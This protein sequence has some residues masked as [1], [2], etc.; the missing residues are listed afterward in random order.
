MHALLSAQP[1]NQLFSH[2]LSIGI[3]GYTKCALKL[4][5]NKKEQITAKNTIMSPNFLVWEF[6]GKAQFP[7]SFGQM[8]RNYVE[9]MPFH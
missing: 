6:C 2:R 8:T 7:H 1:E 4:W 3:Y 5:K 9:T